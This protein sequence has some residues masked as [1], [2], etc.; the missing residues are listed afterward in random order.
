MKNISE[1][2]QLLV[3]YY[4]NGRNTTFAKLI[5]TTESVIRSYIGGVIPKQNV[6]EAI[7]RNCDDVSARWLLTGEGDMIENSVDNNQQPN[8]CNTRELLDII[9][10]LTSLMNQQQDE[11][12]KLLTEVKELRAKNNL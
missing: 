7:V 5:G 3:E 1:R 12:D 10:K 2:I 8:I 9:N 4:G 11:Y 6:L